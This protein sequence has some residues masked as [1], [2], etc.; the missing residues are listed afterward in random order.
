VTE[1]SAS[2]EQPEPVDG[3][4]GSGRRSRKKRHLQRSRE[5][6][7]TVTAGLSL[8]AELLANQLQWVVAAAPGAAQRK[9]PL[10]RD[11]T[12]G[13]SRAIRE[14]D[15]A[16]REL[17]EAQALLENARGTLEEAEALLA[18]NTAEQRF[19]DAFAQLGLQPLVEAE[20]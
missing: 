1:N 5:D 15:A 12:R 18:R 4:N 8:A 19:K 14:V 13:F 11:L 16:Y 3:S 7:L 10:A 17:G 2:D 6:A 9:R 20:G